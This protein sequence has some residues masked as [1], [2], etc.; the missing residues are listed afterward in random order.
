[1]QEKCSHPQLAAPSR[2]GVC[3]LLSCLSV[4]SPGSVSTGLPACWPPPDQPCCCCCTSCI[5][6]EPRSTPVSQ[7]GTR[8]LQVPQFHFSKVGLALSPSSLGLSQLWMTPSLHLPGHSAVLHL[9]WA[10]A[11][12]CRDP[13]VCHRCCPAPGSWQGAGHGK[14]PEPWALSGALAHGDSLS[15][16]S[17]RCQAIVF[18][19]GLCLLWQF[20]SKPR[21]ALVKWL[22][23]VPGFC[24]ETTTQ[25]Q[26]AAQVCL[27]GCSFRTQPHPVLQGWTEPTF[28]QHFPRESL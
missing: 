25:P 17:A 14:A 2:A 24:S 1:M 12:T 8:G 11:V 21:L 5:L 22:D 13:C 10:P 3:P 20:C 4:T 9:T 18:S 27:D 26:P 19:A 23:W 6:P 28:S 16:E 7:T 15:L